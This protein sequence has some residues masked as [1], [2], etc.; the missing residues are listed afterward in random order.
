M[1]EEDYSTSRWYRPVTLAEVIRE[2]QA[3]IPYDESDDLAKRH[4]ERYRKFRD[5][6]ST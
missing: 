2:M 3:N 4:E 5:N 1:I 6:P